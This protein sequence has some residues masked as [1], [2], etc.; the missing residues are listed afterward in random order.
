MTD[1]KPGENR[2]GIFLKVAMPVMLVYGV[3]M[4]LLWFLTSRI[5]EKYAV[6]DA[7]T[8]AKQTVIQ[9]K[10]LR[11]Y[12]TQHV[13][14][15]L[16]GKGD[17]SASFDHRYKKNV[18]PLPATLI[19]DMSDLLREEN[20]QIK[21]YSPYP[22]PNRTT[23]RLDAFATQAWAHFRDGADGV[24]V[25]AQQHGDDTVVRVAM[26]DTMVADS[27]VTCHNS[28]PDTPRT[29]WKL[30][31][32]RGVLEV[33][34]SI[35]ARLAAGRK[36]SH[37]IMW[38]LTLIMLAVLAASY[39]VLQRQVVRPLSQV[40]DFATRIA[41]G[42]LDTAFVQSSKA[43]AREVTALL[44]VLATMQGNLKQRIEADREKAHAAFRVRAALDNVKTNVMVAD[45]DGEIVYVNHAT[46]T[47]FRNAQH[48]IRKVY[49]HF[50]VERL[51]GSNFD[52][53]HRQP[54][55]QRHILQH[56]TTA[57]QTEISLGGRTFSLVANAVINDEGEWLGSVVEWAD[58]TAEVAIEQEVDQLLTTANAGDLSQRI[59]IADKELFFR[60]L[61]A[62]MNQLVEL[63][64]GVVDDTVRMF[65][66][67]ARGDLTERIEADYAGSFGR[68]KDDANATAEKLVQIIAD[69]HVSAD[70]VASTSNEIMMGVT[71]LSQRTEKQA[72]SLEQTAASMEAMT[73]TVR[74]NADNATRAS[75]AARMARERAESGGEVVGE[76]ARAMEAISTAGEK[77][78]DIIG[79]V[80]DI[81]FQTN[82][83][84]LNA[85]VEAARAGEQGRGFAVVAG[86]V[87]SLAQRSAT[88]A[89][90]IK[91]LIGDSVT[92][93]GEGT[94]LVH[95]AAETLTAIV[96]SIIEVSEL[97]AEIAT[98]SR[99]QASGID[100]V[101]RT[102]RQ[103]DETT[104]QNAALVEQAAAA[105]KAM[106]EQAHYVNSLLA[107]FSGSQRGKEGN[108]VRSICPRGTARESTP[109][110]ASASA[111][112]SS[113]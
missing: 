69:I 75:Q 74:Q 3:G 60:T 90:Q 65:A 73:A 1:K 86:E 34:E 111:P 31:D 4:L 29:G 16:V 11:Q 19:H 49:P 2:Q 41:Q 59:D 13:I 32:V 57:H 104:Q 47:M 30:G 85:A 40:L 44:E 6:Q 10:A 22:F 55:H 97:T 94:R 79:V 12:Y 63:C 98:A 27:C 50:D 71:S 102:V 67:L 66:A 33:D 72:F 52:E 9:F 21:L 103:L 100:R 84:A 42:A 101:N 64:A 23:R 107:F 87:R 45:R 28:H 36:I 48:D 92:R 70:V 93:V 14:S 53:F 20:I 95:A 25:R 105:S 62:G 5:V 24:F 82:L 46:M 110:F 80:D 96:A 18:I 8:S 37:N 91:E 89:K 54:A 77:V 99:E 108:P 35:G 68:L 81:A 83:L 38:T 106:T 113:R 78:A 43:L 58:R 76:V 15:K 17:I 88:A 112:H 26:A 7:V 61:S 51:Q 39:G 56:L 109:D